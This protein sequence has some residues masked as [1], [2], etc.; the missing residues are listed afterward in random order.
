MAIRLLSVYGMPVRKAEI[1]G[2]IQRAA[3]WLSMQTPVNTEDRV[4]QLLGLS[5]ANA[6]QSGRQKR[7]RELLSLQHKDGG[8]GQ[9]Q[10]WESD[11]YATGQ[12]L[13]T[14]SEL[15]IPSSNATAQRG[16]TFLLRTQADDGS[17]HVK[18][19]ALKIQP[20]FESGFPYGSDQWISQTGTAWAVMGLSA[21]TDAGPRHD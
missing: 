10:Y 4:M 21:A 14:L 20:Y 3:A 12:V 17:W 8:W 15:G 6:D 13:V 7:L 1:T 19:R 11:A 18:S 2:R 9:T 5:W 16:V